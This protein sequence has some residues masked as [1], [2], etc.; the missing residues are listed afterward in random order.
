MHWEKIFVVKKRSNEKKTEK[1]WAN[2][3]YDKI[4]DV[5]PDIALKTKES[6]KLTQ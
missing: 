5:N 2:R 1:L 6:V 3:V 4:V